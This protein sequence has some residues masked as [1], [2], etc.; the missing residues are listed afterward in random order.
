M[1]IAQKLGLHYRGDR[2]DGQVQV[3]LLM[4][5]SPLTWERAN[6]LVV[7]RRQDSDWVGTVAVIQGLKAFPLVSHD[8]TVWGKFLV[9]G[10]SALIRKLTGQVDAEP[11]ASARD[12][13]VRR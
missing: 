11:E 7:G 2:E 6:R 4:S 9:Y 1:E 3:R 10:D 8:M 5:E 12:G 13:P